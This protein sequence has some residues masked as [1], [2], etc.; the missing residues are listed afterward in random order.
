MPEA[1][2]NITRF[3]MP[4]KIDMVTCRSN[5]FLTRGCDFHINFSQHKVIPLSKNSETLIDTGRNRPILIIKEAVLH[6]N[7]AIHF[8]MRQKEQLYAK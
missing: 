5:I 8:G 6:Q 3:R 1:I 4:H 2:S 7:I